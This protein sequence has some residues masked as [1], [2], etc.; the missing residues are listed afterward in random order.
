ML[1]G[2]GGNVTLE[3]ITVV[4]EFG[5]VDLSKPVSPSTG[6]GPGTGLGFG[7]GTGLGLRIGL[8]EGLGMGLGELGTGLGAG[9]P[10]CFCH[11]IDTCAVRLVK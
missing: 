9:L 7:L 11:L 10:D 5:G 2:G 6:V 8:G 1:A 4:L 3:V